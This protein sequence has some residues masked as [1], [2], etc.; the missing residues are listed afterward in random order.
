[1]SNSPVVTVA[2]RGRC[3]YP[4]ATSPDSTIVTELAVV[5]AIATDA[6]GPPPVSSTILTELVVAEAPGVPSAAEGITSSDD[7]EELYA[8]LH[9][10]GGSSASAALDEDSRAV[11]ERL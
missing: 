3:E 5:E 10:E 9:G 2:T 11:I 7:L 1:M 4:P 6:P 8:S